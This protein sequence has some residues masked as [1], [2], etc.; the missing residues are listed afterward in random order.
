MISFNNPTNTFVRKLRSC[1][2]HTFLPTTLTHDEVS[3]LVDPTEDTDWICDLIHL[4]QGYS[5]HCFIQRV[6]I[7]LDFIIVHGVGFATG[8]V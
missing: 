4:P 6:E 5:M 3:L 8:H 7:W 1:I 2:K